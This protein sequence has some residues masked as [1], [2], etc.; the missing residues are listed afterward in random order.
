[1]VE[2]RATDRR[3]A[4]DEIES[5]WQKNRQQRSHIGV[6]HRVDGSVVDQ[7]SFWLSRRKADRQLV[8][9]VGGLQIHNYSSRRCSEAHHLALV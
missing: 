2:V 6:E 3:G 9:S 5:L 7:K 1:L 8:I 4:F